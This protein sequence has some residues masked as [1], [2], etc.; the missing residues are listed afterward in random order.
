MGLRR[1]GRRRAARLPN[2]APLPNMAGAARRRDR[3][4]REAS[5]HYFH[6]PR[7]R[8]EKL[9]RAGHQLQAIALEAHEQGRLLASNGSSKGG[10]K[11]KSVKILNM[12]ENRVHQRCIAAGLKYICKNEIFDHVI[13]MDADGEDRPDEIKNFIKN[14]NSLITESLFFARHILP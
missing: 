3:G 14:N 2:M 9:R 13:I 10:K 11:I 4:G 1:W 5:G 12:K 7:S 6:V 8:V